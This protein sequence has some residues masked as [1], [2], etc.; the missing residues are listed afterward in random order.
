METLLRSKE[1]HTVCESALC[2]NLGQCFLRGT[3]TFMILGGICTRHCTFCAVQKGTPFPPD[4]QEPEHVSEAAG[5]LGLTYV[6]VTSVTRDDLPDG[7]AWQF[8][9]TL[10]ALHR[11]NGGVEVEVLIPDFLGDREALTVVVEERPEVIN[12]NVETVPRLYPAVRPQ[13]SYLRSLELLSVVKDLNPGTVTK[14]GLM[15][16]LGETKDE[17]LGVMRDLREARCDLLTI[18]QYLRPSE[19]HHPVIHYVPPGEFDEYRRIGIDMGFAAVASGPLV[20]SSYRA[21]DLYRDTGR[22]DNPLS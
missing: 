17:V 2:P 22:S 6:V 11:E 12:H 3:A 13:A 18:G 20:R 15:L 5:T 21:A 1:L 19:K 7:G 8:A 4:P 9:L 16:G 14:S 10:A